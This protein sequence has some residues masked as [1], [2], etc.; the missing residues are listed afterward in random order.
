MK[1]APD[2]TLLVGSWEFDGSANRADSI[3]KRIDWLIREHLE[4]VASSPQW[5]DWEVLYVDPIDGRFW[6]LT[7]PHGEL[8][9]GGPPQLE[10]ISAE[11]AKR[12]YQPQD[13]G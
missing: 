3:C 7:Y 13:E 6:E 5:G 2:E 8:Q 9:G 1:L 12:K 4:R 10:S 11:V